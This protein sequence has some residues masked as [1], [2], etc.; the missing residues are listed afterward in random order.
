MPVAAKTIQ[1]KKEGMGGINDL[2]GIEQELR[3]NRVLYQAGVRL[4]DSGY[5]ADRVLHNL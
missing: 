3:Y 4:Y 1:R 2:P 5:I